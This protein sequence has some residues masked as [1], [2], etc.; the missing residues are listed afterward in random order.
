MAFRPV[1]PTQ[2]SASI[3]LRGRKLL[4]GL[5]LGL[6]WALGGMCESAAPLPAWSE[7]ASASWWKERLAGPVDWPTEAATL[8]ESLLE[9][10]K[11]V[12]A[13]KATDSSHF[14]GWLELLVWSSLP[15]DGRADAAANWLVSKEGSAAL[16]SAGA[17]PPLRRL[18]LGN[19]SPMDD[20][21]KAAEILCRIRQTHAAAVSKFPALAVA[22]SLVWDQPFPAQWPHLWVR[23]ENC[24]T[25]N[26]DPVQRFAYYVQRHAEKKFLLDLSR[27]SVREL[28]FVVDTPLEFREL[29]YAQQTDLKDPKRLSDLFQQVRYDAGRMQNSQLEWPHGGYRLIDVGKKGGICADQAFFTSQVGKALGIP[30]VL[31]LGQGSS[32]GHAWIGYVGEAGRWNF[33]V[34]RY[35]DQKYVSGSGWDPQTWRWVTDAQLRFLFQA[36][37]GASGLRSRLLTRWALMNREAEFYPRLLVLARNAWPR[38]FDIWDLLAAC[39]DE[40]NLGFDQRRTVWKQWI[41]TFKDDR[42]MRFQGQTKLLALLETQPDKKSA[43]QLRAQI[44]RENSGGRFD[45]AIR[46]A[47]APVLELAAAGKWEEAGQKY[48]KILALFKQKA[49]GDLFYNLVQPYV[50]SALHAGR[51]PLAKAALELARPYFKEVVELST[52][53]VD[54]RNLTKLVAPDG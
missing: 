29:D 32:G 22:I 5:A 38:N 44:I 16:A 52:L 17:D 23:K 43:E 1:L 24:A 53:E 7:A 28:M 4:D 6:L 19:L 49:G 48:P 39:L 9:A 33:E 36:S 37:P 40:R 41:E 50:E 3:F 31:L 30:T 20:G 54:L 2:F 13:E 35:S 34:A 21:T 12:G 14:L 27:L 51:R 11:T 46:L 26:P 10:Q 47:S 25:G 45:L 15:G 8:K 18:F 42:D